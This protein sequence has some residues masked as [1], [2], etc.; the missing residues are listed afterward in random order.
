MVCG[1]NVPRQEYVSDV[2][3]FDSDLDPLG[4]PYQLEY[5]AGL[6]A[7]EYAALVASRQKTR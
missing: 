1:R 4:H 6:I 5:V 2:L 3:R 7:Q